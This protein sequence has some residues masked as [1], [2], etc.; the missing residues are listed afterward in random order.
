VALEESWAGSLHSVESVEIVDWTRVVR[1]LCSGARRASPANPRAIFEPQLGLPPIDSVRRRGGQ[2]GMRSRLVGV[3]LCELLDRAPSIALVVRAVCRS[4]RVKKLPTAIPV[5]FCALRPSTLN[6]AMSGSE[7]IEAARIQTVC[8]ERPHSRCRLV[9]VHGVP[10]SPAHFG[11]ARLKPVP[12]GGLRENSVSYKLR[13][14]RVIDVWIRYLNLY[15]P[16]SE[17]RR[18]RPVAIPVITGMRDREVDSIEHLRAPHEGQ[19]R[20]RP[21]P[22]RV[23]HHRQLSHHPPGTC[24]KLG[25]PTPLAKAR[26]GGQNRQPD[27]MYIHPEQFRPDRGP[28]MHEC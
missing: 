28:R 13:R 7:G 2:V 10:C 18:V 9:R 5:D 22:H 6:R 3:D 12:R 26:L 19:Q 15:L 16:P 27:R 4:A 17:D 20:T 14:I 25:T 21:L 8:I 11:S 24:H 23:Q 1:S